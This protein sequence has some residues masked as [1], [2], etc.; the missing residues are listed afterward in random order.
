M[1]VTEYIAGCKIF[2]PEPSDSDDD[3]D[4]EDDDD[5]DDD[6]NADDDDQEQE[7][8]EEQQRREVLGRPGLHFAL[9]YHF[10]HV[11]VMMMMGMMMIM[12][13]TLMMMMTWIRRGR[14]TFVRAGEPQMFNIHYLLKINTMI[15]MIIILI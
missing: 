2:C 10:E 11:N 15:I 3:D 8:Q 6:Y 1:S 12:M 13:I 4:A 5:D 9:Q 14:A 7:K